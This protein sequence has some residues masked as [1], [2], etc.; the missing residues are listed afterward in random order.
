MKLTE[1]KIT[2][3]IN[4]IEEINIDT[5]NKIAFDLTDLFSD[6]EMNLKVIAINPEPKNN[7]NLK[8]E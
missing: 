7:L 5:A 6:Y 3:I 2:L 1:Y 4:S 8:S